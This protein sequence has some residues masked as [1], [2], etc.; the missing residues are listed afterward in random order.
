MI[1]KSCVGQYFMLN[2]IHRGFRGFFHLN[3]A[4]GKNKFE[5]QLNWKLVLFAPRAHLISLF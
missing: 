1:C 3:F 5:L 4:L 2:S